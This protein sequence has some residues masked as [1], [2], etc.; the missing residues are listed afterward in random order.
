MSYLKE[1]PHFATADMP[2]LSDGWVDVSWHHD[3]MPRF[4][5]EDLGLGLWVDHSDPALAAWPNQE[6][7]NLHGIDAEG[8]W[9]GLNPLINSRDF[10]PVAAC[11]A[12]IVSEI[13]RQSRCQ[14]RD[15]GR[16]VCADCG[17]FL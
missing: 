6:R 3:L 12:D 8:Q 5:N 16:G 15:T 2:T 17:E 1:F 14:H 10:A 4:I 13:A 9:D 7:F 11:I